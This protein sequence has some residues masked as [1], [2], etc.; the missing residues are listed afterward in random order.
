MEELLHHLTCMVYHVNN[1]IP[2]ETTRMDSW[3]V[4]FSFFFF[5]SKLLVF[6]FIFGTEESCS[7]ITQSAQKLFQHSSSG[8][9]VL[10]V[11]WFG[12]GWDDWDH[13]DVVDGGW[14]KADIFFLVACPVCFLRWGGIF[15][16]LFSFLSLRNLGSTASCNSSSSWKP[17]IWETSGHYVRNLGCGTLISTHFPCKDLVHHPIETTI[18]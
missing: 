11:W 18:F 9:V 17:A 2:R 8:L 7:S 15:K 4:F 12:D 5:F 6:F 14:G 10:V 16:S 1:G 3:K 13:W